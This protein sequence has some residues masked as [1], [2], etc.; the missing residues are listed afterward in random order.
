[1]TPE[2]K[3]ENKRK[4]KAIRFSIKHLVQFV[5]VF[6]LFMTTASFGI[7]KY[8]TLYPYAI[9]SNDEV[10]CYVLD[11]SSAGEA[12]QKAVSELAP[13]D[14]EVIL[15][16]ISD[17]LKIERAETRNVDEEIKSSDAAAE[18]IISAA[19]K[20]GK[21]GL[22]IRIV[23]TKVEAREFTPD[24]KY[25]QDDTKLAGTTVVENEGSDGKIEA[26]VNMVTLD[27]KTERKRDL[28]VAVVDEG[29]PA[30]IVKGTLGLPEGEDWKTYEGDPVYRDGRELA[31]TA[32]S[33]AGK[34]KYVLGGHN[35]N[36]GV[37]CV[38]FVREMYR[39]YGIN[40]SSHLKKEGIAVSYKD[41]R[42]GDILCF[43]HHFGIYLGNGRMV[44][45]ANPKADVVITGIGAGGKLVG[46]RRIVV[47]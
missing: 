10:L 11:K 30:V 37:D 16:D 21:E 19:K 13:E 34:L 4:R 46:V 15:F 8:M 40:L 26:T 31:A 3:T 39:L 25:V 38:G 45:A 29:D 5:C 1:M 6:A 22:D 9:M 41:A 23:S 32:S 33:Y 36:T 35:I 18:T 17:S 12:V 42:P 20:D 28:D 14:A 27:G 43:G 44:H 47:P 7:T 2:K 24:P